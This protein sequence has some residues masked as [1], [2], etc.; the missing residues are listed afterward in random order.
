MS[1]RNRMID[2]I[3]HRLAAGIATTRGDL[4]AAGFPLAVLLRHYAAAWA[5]L[6]AIMDAGKGIDITD[7]ATRRAY[8]ASQI[9]SERAVA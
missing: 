1:T 7:P 6:H 4:L 2:F 9:P 5:A 8:L 3:G